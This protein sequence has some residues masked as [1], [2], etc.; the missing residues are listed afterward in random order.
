MALILTL[1]ET[2]TDQALPK[3]DE[4][5]IDVNIDTNTTFR[6][7]ARYGVPRTA[8]IVGGGNFWTDNTY[9][10]SAGDT[11]TQ[12]ESEFYLSGGSYRLFFDK[13][14]E[15]I[16]MGVNLP[17]LNKDGFS[18]DCTQMKY[19]VPYFNFNAA[20]WNIKNFNADN[21]KNCNLLNISG[22]NMVDIDVADFK[23]ITDTITSINI[24][25]TSCYGDAVD[26]FGN[27]VNLTLLVY[28]ST[29]CTGAYADVCDAMFA[30]GRTSGRMLISAN[31][32]AGAKSITFTEN[33]WTEE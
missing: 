9:T 19:C 24:S 14:Y 18:F 21:M 30:E 8:R 2:V 23:K 26:A 25:N 33:G 20:N 28:G 6:Y 12:A 7:V 17:L 29:E 16:E 5:A 13:K 11:V 22:C 32:G 15:I 27:K 1:D 10:T 31:D 3:L 4:V